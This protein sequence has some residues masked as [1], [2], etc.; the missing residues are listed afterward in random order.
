MQD[1]YNVSGMWNFF[2][3]YSSDI[4]C[5]TTSSSMLSQRQS[6]QNWGFLVD[7]QIPDQHW[8]MLHWCLHSLRT[9][10]TSQVV[11]RAQQPHL[12][13]ETFDTEDCGN[14]VE[15]HVFDKCHM[16]FILHTFILLMTYLCRS[17]SWH[18]WNIGSLDIVT[19][20]VKWHMMPPP[21]IAT[22]LLQTAN[23]FHHREWVDEFSEM[24][25][26]HFF[27]STLTFWA[28]WL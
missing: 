3:T 12:I 25:Y 16:S 17:T 20:A 13:L 2:A 11:K 5:S 19:V 26:D 23:R 15:S 22:E 1:I 18:M 14:L 10:T 4:I 24:R 27:I 9:S 6:T 28:T 8:L 21:Y 7:S